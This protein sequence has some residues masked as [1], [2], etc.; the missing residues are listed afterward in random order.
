MSAYVNDVPDID[1]LDL[2]FSDIASICMQHYL[3]L[4]RGIFLAQKQQRVA[5]K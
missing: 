4:I 3:V 2:I 1:V 5:I